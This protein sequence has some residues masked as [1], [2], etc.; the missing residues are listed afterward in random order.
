MKDHN[1]KE[2]KDEIRELLPWYLN[3]TLSEDE[4]KK[5]EAHLKECPM[6]QREL[7]ELGWLSSG[8]KQVGK[9]E[10]SL[11]IESDK[12]VTFAEEPEKLSQEQKANI[13]EHLQSCP[14]CSSELQTLNSVNLE[15]ERQEKEAERKL[16][17]E[18][19][20]LEKITEKLVWLL[21]KPAFA[22]MIVLLLAYPAARW[23]FAP[24]G[25]EVSSIPQV[26][27]ERIY[28]LSEQNRTL[29]EPVSVFRNKEDKLVRVGIP[30]WPDL[31]N[32]SYELVIKDESSE[33]VFI[34]KDFTDFGEQGFSQLVLNTDSFPDS[35]YILTINEI[36][37]EN[38]E[39]SSE[40]NF[41]FR[42]VENN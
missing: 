24:S 27:P 32:Y 5:V 35:R 13:E 37:K 15:L 39:L 16:I 28:V 36:D 12:L 2:C 41:P 29:A 10:K 18:P 19:S 3:R 34:I 14:L 42:I 1:S 30:F 21:C 9:A 38:S 20:V 40:T 6:C 33:I 8:V 23:L 17:K 25:P 31:D 26:A 11:H 22:Y 7:G 4:T